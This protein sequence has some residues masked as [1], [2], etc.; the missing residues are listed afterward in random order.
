MTFDVWSRNNWGRLS[1][2]YTYIGVGPIYKRDLLCVI[3]SQ[4]GIE[5]RNTMAI[6]LNGFG[7]YVW[8]N[9]Q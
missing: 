7:L 6:K 2:G 8:F 3:A 5:C 9:K 4:C 1:R